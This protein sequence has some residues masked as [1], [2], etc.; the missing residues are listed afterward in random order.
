[1]ISI[2]EIKNVSFRRANFGGYRPEDVDKFIDDVQF[3]YSDL[4][5]E[6]VKLLAE[7]KEL[8]KYK[9]SYN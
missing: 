1:M 2:D 7:I 3:S 6:K 5:N 8:R 9:K 4:L